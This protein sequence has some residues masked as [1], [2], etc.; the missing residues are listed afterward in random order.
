MLWPGNMLATQHR[1]VK[2]IDI[3]TVSMYKSACNFSVKCTCI[4]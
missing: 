4:W 1:V 2:S 3:A